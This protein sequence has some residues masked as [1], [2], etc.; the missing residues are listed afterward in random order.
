M[1]SFRSVLPAR[2]D[3]EP[4]REIRIFESETAELLEAPQPIQ[5]R[6]MLFVLTGLF[7]SLVLVAGTMR[8][9]RVVTSSAGQIVTV[10]PT[11]VLGAL[12]Q[13]IIKTLDVREG[14]RVTKGQ[15]L[16]TL[17][18]TFTTAD[19]GALKAQ[20]A[21]LS[22]QIAR[23]QAELAQKPFVTPPP[24]DKVTASYYA[25]QTEY[26]TQRK[27]QFDAQIRSYNEQI[28]QHKATLAKYQNDMAR[29]GER[30]RISKQIE[31]CLL[32]TSPSPRD[33]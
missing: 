15:L 26:H 29:Y 28:A 14:Q 18:P 6:I 11:T 9:D 13:S 10:E 12:D 7:A 33:S 8:I 22:A 24:T 25:M 16:A 30:A 19:V 32:Y 17:D 1:K 4:G 5:T 31:D 27:A 21:N 20:V 2:P 23:A 3:P